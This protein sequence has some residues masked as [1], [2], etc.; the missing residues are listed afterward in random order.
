MFPQ[1]R[2]LICVLGRFAEESR[3]GSK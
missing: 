2:N 3:C 1:H